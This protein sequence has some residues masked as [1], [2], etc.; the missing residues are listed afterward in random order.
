LN[1]LL[2]Q[3]KLGPLKITAVSKDPVCPN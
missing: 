2:K 1:E 3:N